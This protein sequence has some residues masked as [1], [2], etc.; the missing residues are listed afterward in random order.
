MV[1]RSVPP[2]F[3]GCVR[4]L[5]SLSSITVT[6]TML[7]RGTSGIICNTQHMIVDMH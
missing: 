1:Q 5:D 2:L 7:S 6:G 3:D 4:D